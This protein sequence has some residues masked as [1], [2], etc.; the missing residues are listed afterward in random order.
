MICGGAG[1]GCAA[2]GEEEGMERE[3]RAGALR[4]RHRL[5]VGALTMLALLG[6]SAVPT[7]A[8]A[9]ALPDGR[10]YELVTPGLNGARIQ[11]GH[12]FFTQA[13]ADGDQLA[14]VDTDALDSCS[15]SGVYNA[16]VATRG[17]TGWAITCEAIPFGPPESEYLGTEVVAMSSDLS[18]VLVLTDQPLTSTAPPGYNLFLGNTRTGSYTALTDA[19]TDSTSSGL[20]DIGVSADYSHVFF[21]PDVAQLSTDPVNYNRGS[22]LYQWTDGQLTIVNVLPSGKLAKQPADL[23]GGS[24][25]N[26]SAIS[27]DGSA[28]LFQDQTSS[29]P[30][31]LYLRLG[32][33]STVQVDASQRTTADPNGPQSASAVGITPDGSQ[34]LFT[35]SAE[36]TNNANT[37]ESG[38]T[39][40]DAGSDLYDYDVTTGGLTDLTPDSRVA[41]KATGAAVQAVIGASDDGSYVYFI[42]T[43]DLATG[44]TSGQPNLYVEHDGTPT[45][46]ASATGLVNS[47]AYTTPDGQSLAFEST[48]SLTGY[49]NTDQTTGTADTEV[50]EYSAADN[51][52]QCASCRPDGVAPT[53]S[54]TLPG[55]SSSNGV[56]SPAR[57]VSDNGSR[58]FFNSS[59]QVVAGASDGLQN[60]YE[61]EDGVASLISPGDGASPAT[62]V[63][64][65]ASG[66]DVFFDSYDDVVPPLDSSLESAIWDARVGGG[67]PVTSTT[68]GVCTATVQCRA[69]GTATAGTPSI[70]TSTVSGQVKS[71]SGPVFSVRS[72]ALHGSTLILRVRTRTAGRL[73]ASGRD[74]RTG[75]HRVRHA[76]TVTVALRLTP[77]AKAALSRHHRLR[78]AIR[79][80][81]ARRGGGTRA[82]TVHITVKRR[83]GR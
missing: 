16:M 23:A 1:T 26:L 82:I 28:V 70:S 52:V 45:F 77:H 53:G 59:D 74:V 35:S 18:Q 55:G 65:S 24:T 67:F 71:G 36:L 51:T 12:Q 66:D 8:R 7:A 60:V 31:P 38:S 79:L 80:R 15:S 72:H 22:D 83:G 34:V 58:V 4:R 27:A 46:I 75:R 78:L 30:G 21:N 50:F 62:L 73:T 20:G 9:D 40:D 56:N 41:D 76:G 3:V 37:G 11:P 2:I 61:F 68:E 14:F 54:S 81:F 63:D 39:P 64:A 44:A 69:T 42:A 47:S 17:T 6:V 25:N 19:S 57:V 10:A 43:G 32:G 5:T 29:G 13:T 48:G 49:D 33:S